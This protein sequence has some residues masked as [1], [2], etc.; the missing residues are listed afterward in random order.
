MKVKVK[1]SHCNKINLIKCD[2]EWPNI[3][4]PQMVCKYCNKYLI[5]GLN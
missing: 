3:I 1:C 5:I 4:V 2:F